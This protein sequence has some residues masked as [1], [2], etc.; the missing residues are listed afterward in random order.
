MPHGQASQVDAT[1]ISIRHLPDCFAR[2][3]SAFAMVLC[4]RSPAYNSPNAV[5][6]L[7]CSLDHVTMV[8]C[9]LAQ[10]YES[11]VRCVLQLG[12]LPSQVDVQ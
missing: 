7:Q 6:G 3:L 8:V 12:Q 2:R 10:V 4:F 9:K 5:K 11:I 1:V